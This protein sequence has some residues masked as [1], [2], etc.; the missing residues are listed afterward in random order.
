[1]RRLMDR[2]REPMIV[3][4][5]LAGFY[6]DLIIAKTA[7]GRADLVPVT[8]PTWE[9]MKEFGQSVSLPLLLTGQQT[10]RSAETQLRNTTQP[11]LWLEVTLMNLLP[12]TQVGMS[13]GGNG[14]IA[15]PGNPHRPARHAHTVAVRTA[16]RAVRHSNLAACRARRTCG[17]LCFPCAC[18]GWCD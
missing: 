18:I 9:A 7:G 5:N 8:P 1:V 16:C 11:R 14:A 10:L 17:K 6:R 15:A 12:S 13:S 4:Q 3:L 2:G